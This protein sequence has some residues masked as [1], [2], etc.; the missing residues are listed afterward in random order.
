MTT[1]QIQDG[2]LRKLMYVLFDRGREA[3]VRSEEAAARRRSPTH[4]PLTRSKT[5]WCRGTRTHGVLVVSEKSS[6]S[7][8]LSRLSNSNYIE[9]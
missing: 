5:K 1:R 9:T 8:C 4:H 6:P 7:F 3:A 2:A